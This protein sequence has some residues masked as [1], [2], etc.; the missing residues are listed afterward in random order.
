MPVA[1]LTRENTQT[2]NTQTAEER[3]KTKLAEIFG[4]NRRI[5]SIM[6]S[7]TSSNNP[8]S[9][10]R[11]SISNFFGFSNNSF[12]ETEFQSE[13]APDES[14]IEQAIALI[15][16]I[17]DELRRLNRKDFFVN[18]EEK[19]VKANYLI[20]T[21]AG[22]YGLGT[23]Q[24]LVDFNLSKPLEFINENIT[25]FLPEKIQKNQLATGFIIG[26]M[27][28][29]L[30]A[31]FREKRVMEDIIHHRAESIFQ[32]YQ[33]F[34]RSKIFFNF[35]DEIEKKGQ[36]IYLNKKQQKQF[37]KS[38]RKV[39]N[40]SLWIDR[41]HRKKIKKSEKKSSERKKLSDIDRLAG[42]YIENETSYGPLSLLL[43]ATPNYSKKPISF[44]KALH[45]QFIENPRLARK[46]STQFAAYLA[47]LGMEEKPK[48][49]SQFKNAFINNGKRVIQKAS[50]YRIKRKIRR[51]ENKSGIKV[52]IFLEM[53]KELEERYYRASFVGG[54]LRN[55]L[56][57]RIN[58]AK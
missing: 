27:A 44:F 43:E 16:S 13:Q 47:S 50:D 40:A 23:L 39:F 26:I 48:K 28:T 4:I 30:I 51:F 20:L 56:E 12:P 11:S 53:L 18:F 54:Y 1:E 32:G 45:Y 8:S 9:P 34:E 17:G 55:R 57:E 19:F 46:L 14:P 37:R 15:D 38:L 52:N 36:P 6:P 22:T 5:Q 58:L 21:L 7:R 41:R 31:R 49:R 10:N 3:T 33:H 24:N 2:S 42:E 29:S 25:N 35:L